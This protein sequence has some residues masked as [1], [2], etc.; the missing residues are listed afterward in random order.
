MTQPYLWRPVSA[1]DITLSWSTEDDADLHVFDP[2]GFH[3]YWGQ[4]TSPTGGTLDHG[5]NDDCYDVVSNP[6]EH[7]SYTTALAGNW[8]V[9]ARL[10]SWCTSNTS[11]PVNITVLTQ[12]LQP[13]VFSG[14]LTG[15]GAAHDVVYNFT[16]PSGGT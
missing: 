10:Y 15:T 6:Y 13:S 5:S 16:I 12:G 2:T 4:P 9:H 7:A 8:S 3:L 1:V 11:V 14:V